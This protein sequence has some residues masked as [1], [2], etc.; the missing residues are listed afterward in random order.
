MQ[1]EI[2]IMKI[3]EIMNI[4]MDIIIMNMIRMLMINYRSRKKWKIRSEE[5][6]I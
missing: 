2:E 5:I 1:I 4:E 3:L 6:K